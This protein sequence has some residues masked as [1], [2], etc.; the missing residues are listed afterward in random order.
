MQNN[1]SNTIVESAAAI[2]KPPLNI[3]S[4][5]L[6]SNP[7]P[8]VSFDCQRCKRVVQRNGRNGLHDLCPQCFFMRGKC[9]IALDS[10]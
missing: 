6:L 5:R 4:I 9:Y 3:L 8:P 10:F 1:Q 7:S 2:V